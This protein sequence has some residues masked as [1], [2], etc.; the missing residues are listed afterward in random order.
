VRYFKV[1]SIFDNHLS[2]SFFFDDLLFAA[3]FLLL[4]FE[5]FKLLF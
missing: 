3:L 2:L 4:F 5:P 1:N